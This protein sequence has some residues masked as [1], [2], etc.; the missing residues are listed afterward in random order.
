MLAQ[1]RPLVLALEI[2]TTEQARIDRFLAS[3]GD[4][5]ARA[6]LVSGDFWTFP[7]QDGRR[8]QATVD[9]LAAAQRWTHE[10]AHAKNTGDASRRRGRSNRSTP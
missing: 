4:A 6:E 2:P 10:K 5:A 1:G 8:S 9:L 3:S 7:M